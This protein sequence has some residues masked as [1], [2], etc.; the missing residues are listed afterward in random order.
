MLKL[1]EPFRDQEIFIISSNSSDLDFKSKSFFCS[2][3]SIFCSLDPGSQNLVLRIQ[4][5]WILSTEINII[6]DKIP[7]NSIISQYIT[8]FSSS[9]WG[10]VKE[11]STAGNTVGNTLGNTA[12]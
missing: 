12:C 11:A 3:W 4:R 8:F 5:I 9:E 2:F 1:N 7:Q 10:H 6:L